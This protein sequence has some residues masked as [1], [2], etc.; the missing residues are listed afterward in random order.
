MVC[1]VG[2]FK[3][4]HFHVG[5]VEIPPVRLVVCINTPVADDEEI[6]KLHTDG[7][8]TLRRNE[9]EET[10]PENRDVGAG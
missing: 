6:V 1:Y 2:L 7:C 3:F 10:S 4:C 5:P 9:R 8:M